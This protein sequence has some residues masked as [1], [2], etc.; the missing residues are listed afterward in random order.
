[1][2]RGGIETKTVVS[3]TGRVL[4][5]VVV[6]NVKF[7]YPRGV[8]GWGPGVVGKRRGFAGPAPSARPATTRGNCCLLGEPE[9]DEDRSTLQV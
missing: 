3:K 2:Q 5:W 4:A 9:E 6:R 8:C 1:M 7:R